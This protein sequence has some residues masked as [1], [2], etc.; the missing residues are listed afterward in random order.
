MVVIRRYK[1][2]ENINLGGG[3]G[4]SEDIP[5]GIKPPQINIFNMVIPILM[6]FCS[7]LKLKRGKPHKP[8]CHPTKCDVI[9]D[10]K[11]FATVYRRTP[12]P[13]QIVDVVQS[14]VALQKQVQ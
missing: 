9:N 7:L 4:I 8:A 12:I 6:H 3:E 2:I 5:P 10:V 13:L 11:L 1:C 14:D